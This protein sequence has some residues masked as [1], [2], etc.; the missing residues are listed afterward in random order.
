MGKAI[1]QYHYL[2]EIMRTGDRNSPE[3]ARHQE[4]YKKI[5]R[6]CTACNNPDEVCEAAECNFYS[7]KPKKSGAADK[8]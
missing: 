3:F 6:F 1:D 4:L 7:L 2:L 8:S 5:R